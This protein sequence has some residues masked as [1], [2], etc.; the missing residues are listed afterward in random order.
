MT[1]SLSKVTAWGTGNQDFN[2]KIVKVYNS[3]DN[4]EQTFL[5][6]YWCLELQQ[7]LCNHEKAR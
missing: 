2:I 4:K 5:Q 6:D 3:T 1:L 7:P